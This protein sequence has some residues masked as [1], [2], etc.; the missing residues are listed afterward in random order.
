MTDHTE[1]AYWRAR[2]RQ[3]RRRAESATDP[4]D[5]L[6][7]EGLAARCE[8]YAQGLVQTGKYP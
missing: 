8:A 2:A 3:A 1:L 7:Q 6:A 5:R 4:G